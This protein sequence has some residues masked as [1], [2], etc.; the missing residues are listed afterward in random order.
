MFGFNQ[1]NFFI[2]ELKTLKL[3]HFYKLFWWRWNW[4]FL[5]NNNSNK[6]FILSEPGLGGVVGN[7]IG[8]VNYWG[9]ALFLQNSNLK[10][11]TI[12]HVLSSWR[13]SLLLK[14]SW[15]VRERHPRMGISVEFISTSHCIVYELVGLGSLGL[16][17]FLWNLVNSS[18]FFMPASLFA[19]EALSAPIQLINC[20]GSSP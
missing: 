19:P 1:A 2:E 9:P 14:S 15:C 16:F 7:V 4:F 20:K 8:E 12:L 11:L 18:G 6:L 5:T 13:L 17:L 10:S 3:N